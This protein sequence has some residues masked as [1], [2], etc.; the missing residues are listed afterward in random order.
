MPYRVLALICLFSIIAWDSAA[1]ATPSIPSPDT[2]VRSAQTASSDQPDNP[3][4]LKIEKDGVKAFTCEN[5][6]SKFR[7][8]KVQFD[9]D[10]TIGHLASFLLDLP[11][12]N[13]WQYKTINA[14]VLQHI[15]E[16]ELI[17]YAEFV[18]PWPFDNRDVVVHMK[19]E[20]TDSTMKISYKGIPDFIPEKDGI[21]RVV[22]SASS[23]DAVTISQGKLNVEFRS[24][25]DPGGNLPA[26]LMN[27]F[28]VDGPFESFSELRRQVNRASSEIKAN[29]R[30]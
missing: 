1:Q 28:A 7:M 8:V 24:N 27:Q 17:Y 18:S 2:T 6:D 13:N 11:G 25:V 10:T 29:G 22:S 19:V 9:A 30:H 21:T 4:T 14:A 20:R 12:Y 15:N 5:K 23:L 26:F 3:C 16:S